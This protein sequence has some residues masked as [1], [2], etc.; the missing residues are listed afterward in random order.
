MTN[1]EEYMNNRKKMLNFLY[2]TINHIEHDLKRIKTTVKQIESIN[3]FDETSRDNI[4]NTL[5]DINPQNLQTYF[6]EEKDAN[7]VQG[8][9]DGHFMIGADQ[10]KY[11]V[12]ANYSSKTKLVWWDQLKLKIFPDGKLIYKLVQPIERKHT[13]ATLSIDSDTQ[14]PIAITWDNEIFLLNQAAVSYYKAQPGDQLTI[15]TAN[16]KSSSFAAL[17]SVIKIKKNTENA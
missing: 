16:D 17:E 15:I 6:D 7:V 9:F 1:Q 13:R 10:K 2:N 8:F 4:H 3:P 14:K 5:K 12:P 11:P